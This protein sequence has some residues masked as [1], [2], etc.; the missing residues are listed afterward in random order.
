VAEI[1]STMVGAGFP[2]MAGG[3][4]SFFGADKFARPRGLSKRQLIVFW[5][6]RRE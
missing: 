2:L 6:R 5:F 1:I 4:T 3:G